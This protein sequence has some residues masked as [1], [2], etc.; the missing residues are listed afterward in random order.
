[1]INKNFSKLLILTMLSLSFLG[2]TAQARGKFKL[3][4]TKGNKYLFTKDSVFCE[5]MDLIAHI[6]QLIARLNE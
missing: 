3:T 1:M 6:N 2:G 4:D 5:Q